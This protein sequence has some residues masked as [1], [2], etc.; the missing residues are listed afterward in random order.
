M[1]QDDD[2][3]NHLLDHIAEAGVTVQHISGDDTRPSY[4]HTIGLTAVGAPELL[5]TGL[6]PEHAGPLL[7]AL[8]HEIAWHGARPALGR[9]RFEAFDGLPAF[10]FLPLRRVRQCL[11]TAVDLYGPRVTGRQLVRPD[12]GGRFPWDD[13][14]DSR[15]QPLFCRAP[16]NP[17][18]LAG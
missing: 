2:Y 11:W 3:L 5:V 1:R 8:G 15:D 16:S 13:G 12:P 6:E 14:Y 4:T 18:Q 10:W 9:Y 17:D 7:N